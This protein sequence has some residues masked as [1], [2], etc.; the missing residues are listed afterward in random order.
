[1]LMVVSCFALQG[2]V[3]SVS[4]GDTLTIRT[5]NH[6]TV[7]IRLRGIDAPEHDQAY[8]KQATHALESKL[9]H[10]TITIKVHELDDYGRT[11]GDVYLGAPVATPLDPRQRLVTTKYNPARTWTA[12]NS[13]GI[14]GAYLCVY[15]M[16]G[17]GGYQ[18]V[19]RTLQ[20]WN[21]YRKTA[22]FEQPWLLRFFDQIRFYPVSTEEL[23][24]IRQDFPLGK[25]PL[26]VEDSTFSLA[27][28]RSYL[29]SHEDAIATFQQQREDAFADE[30]ERWKA[31]GQLNFQQQHPVAE[32]AVEALLP[33][34]T[35]SADS[36][37]S[38]SVW[39]VLVAEEQQVAAGEPLMILESMKMEI[40]VF[41]PHAGRV[42]RLLKRQGQSVT[43][44][45]AL[46]WLEQSQ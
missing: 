28:Y 26:R 2:Q 9:R 34:G 24:Q 44:G 18:F 17:P 45:Q 22:A 16:E 32:E 38:G 21:R 27:E 4:D 25:Y 36:P 8:G 13:V 10:R 11:V 30:L 41:A 1:M 7:K 40:E 42:K 14:G 3:I 33:A 39:Q 6:E 15:G 31:S 43:A 23:H 19:G 37:V 5:R 35:T 12:E 29:S 20:M 46:L